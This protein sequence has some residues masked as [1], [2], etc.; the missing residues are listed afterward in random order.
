[1]KRFDKKLDNYYTKKLMK[2]IRE[3]LALFYID[4]L[5]SEGKDMTGKEAVYLYVNKTGKNELKKPRKIIKIL[6]EDSL[7]LLF[8]EVFLK[9]IK[10]RIEIELEMGS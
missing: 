2:K 7:C 10:E 8:D 4:I 9:E 3:K 5:I 6:K 1:M